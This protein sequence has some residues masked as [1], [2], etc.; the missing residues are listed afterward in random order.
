MLMEESSK[1]WLCNGSVTTLAE[2]SLP[3]IL[4]RIEKAC[5]SCL[6]QQDVE[7]NEF[8]IALQRDLPLLDE[9]DMDTTIA[10]LSNAIFVCGMKHD[11]CS[12][13]LSHS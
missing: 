2:S 7:V 3:P 4:V 1:R 11:V 12:P 5:I 9:M 10:V 6:K 8:V 13:S